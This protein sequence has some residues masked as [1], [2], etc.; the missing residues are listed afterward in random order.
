M[1]AREDLEQRAC[2]KKSFCKRSRLEI[3]SHRAAALSSRRGTF[4]KLKLG[5]VRF[6]FGSRHGYIS[7]ET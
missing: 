6:P 2:D 1:S 3:V 7:V 5:G 4:N